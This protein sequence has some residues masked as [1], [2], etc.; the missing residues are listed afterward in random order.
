MLVDRG[1]NQVIVLYQAADASFSEDGPRLDVGASPSRV[2]IADLD[3]DGWAD[4]VVSNTYSGDLSVFYGGPSHQFRPEFRLAGGL[5]AAVVVSQNGGLIRHT[6]DEP[7]GVTAVSF[8][9]SGMTDVVSV[10]SGADRISLLAANAPDGGLAGLSRDNILFNRHRAQPGRGRAPDRRRRDRPRCP[11]PGE[12]RHLG[13]P[14]RRQ[15]GP[16]YDGAHRRRQRSDW[17]G[18]A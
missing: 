3:D 13:F 11:Q 4:L 10:Q 5:G 15:R 1:G 6:S 9:S 14:E 8:D 7:L 12:R 16:R 18:R 17:L 2:T